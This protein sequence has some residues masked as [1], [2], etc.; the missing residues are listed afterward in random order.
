MSRVKL[1]VTDTLGLIAEQRHQTMVICLSALRRSGGRGHL[2]GGLLPEAILPTGL[3]YG[4]YCKTEQL[5]N[6]IRGSTP[7][8]AERPEST[9]RRHS[10]GLKADD[11]RAEY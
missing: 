9:R 11:Q 1:Q 8:A 2:R 3:S 10:S 6:S 4:T 5:P 7:I